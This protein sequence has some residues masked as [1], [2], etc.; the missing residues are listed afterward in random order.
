MRVAVGSDEKTPLTDAAI[1]YLKEKGFE[2]ETYGALADSE[3][4][5]PDVACN[6]AERVASG[7]CHEGV[8]F[9]WTGTGVSIAA[10][11]VP[12]IRAALCADPAT[13]KGARVW[14]RAN[15]LAM[16]LR[17]TSPAVGCEILETWFSTP[18]GSGEDAKAIAKLD[19]IE[20]KYSKRKAK[21]RL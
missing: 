11:K 10:N 16:G 13:A 7:A 21:K 4:D 2:V 9:C 3:P 5:W 20:R 14:N 12:G 17:L 15:I 8:L 1:S 6:V 18:P 19:A